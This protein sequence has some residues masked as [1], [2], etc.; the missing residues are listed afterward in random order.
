MPQFKT[1]ELRSYKCGE[2]HTF[3]DQATDAGEPDMPNCPRRHCHG[4]LRRLHEIEKPPR[5][6][7]I[8]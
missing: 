7:R 1:V 8:S 4:A 2:G 6:I 5:R 3:F